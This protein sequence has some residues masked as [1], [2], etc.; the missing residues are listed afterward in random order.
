M[1]C[2][3]SLFGFSMMMMIMIMMMMIMI[4]IIVLREKES[5]LSLSYVTRLNRPPQYMNSKMFESMRVKCICRFVVL[6]LDMHDYLQ[7]SASLANHDSVMIFCL[8]V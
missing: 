3:L 8:L 5:S 2:P 4:M 1:E 7:V 6:V